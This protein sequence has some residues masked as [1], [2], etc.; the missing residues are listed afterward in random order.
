MNAPTLPQ[1]LADNPRLDQWVTF[2][3]DG[4]AVVSTGRVEIGQGVLTAMIQIAAD[5]LDIAPDRIVLQ[6]GDTTRT[7]NEGFT[8]GSQSIQ[9]GA[10][11]LQLAC[12]EIKLLFLEH[13]AAA[14]HLPLGEL[15]VK[16]GAITCRGIPTGD[17]YW[18]LAATVDLTGRA[19][20]RAAPKTA[21]SHAVVGRSAPRVDLAAKV[22][23][24]EAF[25]HDLAL[26]GMMHARVVRQPGRTASIASID[27]AAIRRSVKQ[28]IEILRSGNFLAI[29]GADEAAVEGGRRQSAGTCHLGRHRADQHH[30]R[31]RA[32]AVAAAVDRSGDRH[33][34]ARHAAARAARMKRDTAG[35]IWRMPRS[36]RHALWR[37]SRTDN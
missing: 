2:R 26:D 34:A 1:L 30:P 17:D 20:A 12:A 25:I 4:K 11:A 32:L 19:T 31:R 14:R 21:A 22:F 27:E 8:A 13:V 15:A 6:S 7:P 29:V 37:S 24:E 28:P 35:P 10:V 36:R 18:T 3:A 33:A 23:G 5:E 9:F 16:N